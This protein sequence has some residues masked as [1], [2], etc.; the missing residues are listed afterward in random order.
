M[1][2]VS[3]EYR[4]AK[5]AEIA[6][7]ALRAFSRRGFHATSMADIIA[8]SGMSAGAIYGIFSSKSDIVFD[9]ASRVIGGR[10]HDIS[11]LADSTPM[12]P[13]SELLGVLMR[14]MIGELGSPAILVQLWGEAVTDLQLRALASG[15]FDRLVSAYRAY[16]SLWQQREHGLDPKAADTVAREQ[17]PLFLAASQG[18]ILQAAIFHDFDP[19]FFLDRVARHLPR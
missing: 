10:V 8:E 9:V 18:F 14:G 7:A 1:P 6:G 16:I 13:P 4:T 19:E 5:R 15:V 11:R 17:T 2:K 12:P 3:E